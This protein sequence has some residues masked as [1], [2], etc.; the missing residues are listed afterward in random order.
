MKTCFKCKR[1]QPLSEFY[2]H[3]AM[4]DGHLNKCK[5]CTKRDVR[6][7]RRRSEA[8]RTYDRK[9]AK[10]PH[11]QALARESL[12]RWR[13][14]NPEAYKA[15]CKLNNAV[16]D[17]KIARLPCEVCGETKVHGHHRDYSKPLEVLWLCARHHHAAHGLTRAVERRG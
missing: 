13:A 4:S 3:S 12:K 5:D 10:L 14:G 8:V 17:G 11:R 6:M 2:R 7:H 16:R 9:R 1:I 15:Q